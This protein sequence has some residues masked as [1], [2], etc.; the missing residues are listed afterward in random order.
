MALQR[1]KI[2]DIPS[3][4]IV[5]TEDQALKYQANILNKW[6][7]ISDIWGY[8][9]APYVL[10]GTSFFTGFFI[11][12]YYRSKFKLLHYG[13]ISTFLP[14]C[15]LP[16]AFSVMTHMEFVLKDVVLQKR[17]TCPVCLEMRASALQAFIGCGFPLLLAPL[18][19]LSMAHK[20]AT[21][22]LPDVISEP[23]KVF[24]LVRVKSAPLANVVFALFI[25]QALVGSVVTY[26]ESKSV[27]TVSQKLA[28]LEKE[29][30]NS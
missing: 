22:N 2:S 16:A 29:L 15:F 17:D 21:Y 24:N 11:N 18:A 1:K 23:K 20:Y 13:R 9:F 28:L 14:V 26:F 3:D 30:E 6:K 25:G 7:H 10:G 5:L 12:S 4:A 8:K 27:I 19:N